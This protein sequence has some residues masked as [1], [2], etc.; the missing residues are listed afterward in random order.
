LMQQEITKEELMKLLKAIEEEDKKIQ[1]KL[2]R[3]TTNRKKSD[4]DW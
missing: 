1:Q 2:R 4:K 3:G